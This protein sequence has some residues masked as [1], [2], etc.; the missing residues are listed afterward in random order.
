MHGYNREIPS[1][2]MQFSQSPTPPTPWLNFPA[3]NRKRLLPCIGFFKGVF[4]TTRCFVYCLLENEL[5]FLQSKFRKVQYL[6]Q[7]CRH[8]TQMMERHKSQMHDERE[9]QRRREIKMK[10]ECAFHKNCFCCYICSTV[11]HHPGTWFYGRLGSCGK[12]AAYVCKIAF[13]LYHPPNELLAC[14]LER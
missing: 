7:N 13:A 14:I 6:R 8:R 2:G 9:R 3:C 12:Y 5:H 11:H 4:N 10:E 1:P